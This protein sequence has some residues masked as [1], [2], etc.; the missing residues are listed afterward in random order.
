MDREVVEHE[1]RKPGDRE[2][3]DKI[4]EELDRRGLLFRTV[5]TRPQVLP[6]HGVS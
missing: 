4:E 3:E 6:G 5:A 1:L 2:D